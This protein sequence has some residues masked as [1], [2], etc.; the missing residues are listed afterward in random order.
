MFLLWWSWPLSFERFAWRNQK[1]NRNYFEIDRELSCKHDEFNVKSTLNIF[2]FN[3]L[4]SSLLEL[5]IQLWKIQFPRLNRFSNSFQTSTPHCSTLRPLT[6]ITLRTLNLYEWIQRENFYHQKFSS[7]NEMF[8]IV[9]IVGM[10]K[11]R[12]WH[13]ITFAILPSRV[14]LTRCVCQRTNIFAK[15]LILPMIGYMF[16]W[17]K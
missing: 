2:S 15:L 7:P 11:A 16:T 4:I 17:R 8:S 10:E 5:S 13:E 14:V 6:F 12:R 3:K 9:N 1:K